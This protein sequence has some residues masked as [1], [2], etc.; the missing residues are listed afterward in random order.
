VARAGRSALALSSV[1]GEDAG[2]SVA[3]CGGLLPLGGGG[4]HLLGEGALLGDQVLAKSNT[5]S[6]TSS[7]LPL[8]LV[9]VV[10][11]RL[12]ANSR[13]STPLSA[14]LAAGLRPSFTAS[15]IAAGLSGAEALGEERLDQAVALNVGLHE[16]AR[17]VAGCQSSR[18]QRH[19]LR[20][21]F[22]W[23]SVR[24]TPPARRSPGSP[25]GRGGGGG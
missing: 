10:H 8:A 14:M 3:L 7:G 1:D 21:S 25:T 5:A 22:S 9:T 18:T 24:P 2:A 23:S 20:R 16:S 17:P 15:D 13:T 19:R 6:R 11:G 4:E 12:A